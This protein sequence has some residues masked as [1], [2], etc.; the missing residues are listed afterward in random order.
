MI[1]SFESQKVDNDY[2]IAAFYSF[3]PIAEKVITTFLSKLRIIAEKHNV[4][5]T[6]L[7]ALEGING[8]ICGPVEGVTAMQKQLDSLDLETPL[9]IKYSYTSR[10]AFRRFKARRKNEIVTM[11]VE[12]VDPCKTTGKYVEPEDWNAFLDD[13]LTLVID[14][15]NEYEISVGSF[16]G[17]VNPRTDSFREFPEWV[18]KKLHSLLKKKSFKKIALFCTG[19]IR[20]EKA[21]ALL[22]REGFP[23]VHHLHGGILRYLEEVPE[24]ESRWNGECF[25]FD[26][27]VALNHKLM[28]GVYKLCFACGMPLSPQDQN[29]KYYIPSIQCHHCVDLFSD[30]DR[31]RF[32]ERQRH[33]ARLGERFPGNSIW[34]SA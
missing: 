22:L 3:S 2:K 10:Q 23:E 21:S 33:I 11:G 17:A 20:C 29:G 28:P 8:T 14:T 30:D 19:G 18:D 15:R 4:R 26:Q 32:R 6:V 5:G 16:D 27:R 34:P 1:N 12:N 25:V 9:E 24:N 13:P 31:E 7:V